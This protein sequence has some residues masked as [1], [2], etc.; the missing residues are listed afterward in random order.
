MLPMQNVTYTKC[1]LYQM[2]PRCNLLPM[3]NVTDT[4]CTMQNVIMQKCTVH[5]VTDPIICLIN[6][7]SLTIVLFMEYK[8]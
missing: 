8:Y 5:N 6:L 7:F 2:L 3:Q 1:Y 4:K